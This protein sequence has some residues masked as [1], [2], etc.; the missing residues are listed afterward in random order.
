MLVQQEHHGL[1]GRGVDG[2]GQGGNNRD[3]QRGL[4]LLLRDRDRAVADVT[5]PDA[6]HVGATQGGPKQ[7]CEREPRLVPIG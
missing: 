7:E 4:G 1:A 3:D 5:P 2:L 6:D